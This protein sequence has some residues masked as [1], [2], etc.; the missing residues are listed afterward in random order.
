MVGN[1]LISQV[2][3]FIDDEDEAPAV[4]PVGM[5]L[6]AV[7]GKELRIGLTALGAALVAAVVVFALVSPVYQSSGMIRIL[8]TE[9]KILYDAQDQSRLRLYDA[10]FN[11][12]MQLLTSRPVLEAAIDRMYTETDGTKPL[13][14]NVI[15]LANM[16][17][18]SGRKGLINL[19]SRSD[20]PVKSAIAVNAV[21]AAFQSSNEEARMRVYDVREQELGNREAVLE[22]DLASLNEEYLAV[23]GEHDAVSLAKAHMAKTAQLEV[24]QGRIEE[25]ENTIAE[26]EST[27]DMTAGTGDSVAIQ[28]ATLLDQAMANMAF[29]RAKRLATL[30]TLKGRYKTT[31]PIR[32]SAQVELEVLEMAI[33]ERQNQIALLGQAGAFLG[34]G[35]GSQSDSTEELRSALSRLLERRD[36]MR[37]EAEDLNG[38]LIRIRGIASEQSHLSELLEETKRALDE[39]MVESQNDLSRSIEVIAFGKAPSGAIEDKRK[40]LAL[41]ALVFVSLG[42]FGTFILGNLFAGRINFS[43][44]MDKQSTNLLCEVLQETDDCTKEFDAAARKL[45]NEIDLRW[46]KTNDQALVIGV[47]G[48]DKEVGVSNMVRAL[49]EHY[50]RTHMK[51]LMIDADTKTNGLT[52]L[53]AIEASHGVLAVAR[54]GNKLEW[55]TKKVEPDNSNLYL[56][57][58]GDKNPVSS[59]E[60]IPLDMVIDEQ[61]NLLESSRANYDLI[62]LDLGV[63]SQGHQSAVA[64]SLTDRSVLVTSAGVSKKQLAHSLSLLE[65]LAPA[66]YVLAMNRAAKLDPAVKAR[67]AQANERSSQSFEK[68]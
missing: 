40:P 57:P 43:D 16:I 41:A 21:I 19:R 42:T 30:E 28:R 55:E 58:A 64:T 66:R 27:G 65:R 45:R 33:E 14:A 20:D 60:S 11:S 67:Y 47:V 26:I 2:R 25:L 49:G 12:E 35:G 5:V 62:L 3:D 52:R 68:S 13:P 37:S 15:E 4:D 1:P 44:D 63:L 38:K 17:S 54:D 10:F 46:P 39:V 23:G 34:D 61:R 50:S 18:V 36:T 59:F 32:Q 8:P 53:C 22:A 48:T 6:R 7:R 24:I 31:H 9:G 29:E 51:V 56:L